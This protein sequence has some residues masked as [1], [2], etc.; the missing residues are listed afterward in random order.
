MM[1]TW[2]SGWPLYQTAY[3]STWVIALGLS[4]SG[5]ML[6]GRGRLFL[7][8][9]TAQTATTS[10]SL[11]FWLGGVSGVL[12]ADHTLLTHLVPWLSATLVSVIA[13][14]HR[15]RDIQAPPDASTVVVF[16]GMGSASMLLMAH[17]PH[18]MAD[19]QRLLTSSLIGASDQ[20]LHLSLIWTGLIIGILRMAYRPLLFVVLDPESARDQGLNVAR[21]EMLMGLMVGTAIG[22]S[23]S[24][25]GLPYAFAYLIIPGLIARQ[26]CRNL[27]S[28]ILVTPLIA[29][30]CSLTGVFLAHG[31][32]LPPAQMSVLVLCLTWAFS[33]WQTPF[34]VGIHATKHTSPLDR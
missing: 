23:L 15:Q 25:G 11:L 9:A 22:L 8:A 10:L 24:V 32:D 7:A 27:R 14:R 13:L 30:A 20:D 28:L 4:L 2:I 21:W 16:L 3:L 33:R 19:I 18:G 6:V 34:R 5:L 29:L 1:E 12:S 26:R 17:H 31:L